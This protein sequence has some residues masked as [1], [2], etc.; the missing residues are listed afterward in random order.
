LVTYTPDD[1][2]TM[3]ALDR[4]GDLLPHPIELAA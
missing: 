3:T 2:E 4:V 1:P